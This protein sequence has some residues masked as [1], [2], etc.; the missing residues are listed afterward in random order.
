M[1]ELRALEEI[2]ALERELQD[3]FG[4]LPEVVSNLVYLLKT[5]ALCRDAGVK[6]VAVERDQVAL[7]SNRP[8][9]AAEIQQVQGLG[10]PARAQGGRIWL[11]MNRDWRRNL[12]CLLELFAG[13]GARSD[14]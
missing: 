14:S 1:A 7:S 6:G 4:V 2:D 3:R 12:V 9:T 10:L 11:A 5:K 8:L 13:R